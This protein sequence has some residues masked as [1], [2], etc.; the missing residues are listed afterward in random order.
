MQCMGAL[1]YKK[2]ETDQSAWNS[3]TAI[4]NAESHADAYAYH[5]QE[6]NSYKLPHHFLNEDGTVGAASTKACQ[7]AIAYLN[8]HADT[9]G[10]YQEDIAAAY[11]HLAA[12]LRDAEA[13]VP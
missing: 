4:P 10:W 8:S 13:E 6:S 1:R 7:A 3:S 12:H 11:N 9:E 5:D 2:S